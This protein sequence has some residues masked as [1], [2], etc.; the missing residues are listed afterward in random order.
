[1][2]AVA[3]NKGFLLDVSGP[4]ALSGFLEPQAGA[5]FGPS[6]IQGLFVTGTLPTTRIPLEFRAWTASTS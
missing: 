5:N 1:M 6:T 3:K 2:Y 4:A